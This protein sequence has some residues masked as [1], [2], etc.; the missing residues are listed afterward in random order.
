MDSPNAAQAS[1]QAVATNSSAKN[2]A[3]R[4]AASSQKENEARLIALYMDLTGCSENAAR[5]VY[6]SVEPD[7]EQQQVST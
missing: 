6:A 1:P 2:N 7:G 5:C 4:P 3:G